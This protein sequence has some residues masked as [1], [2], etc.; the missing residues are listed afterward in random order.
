M[1]T[2]GKQGYLE[3]EVNREKPLMALTVLDFGLC[4]SLA[5]RRAWKLCTR[6]TPSK[7]SL[8]SRDREQQEGGRMS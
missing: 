5:C 4:L 6:L 7:K 3:S 8:Q 2:W 1:H